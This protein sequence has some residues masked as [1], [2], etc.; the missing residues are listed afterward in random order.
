MDYSTKVLVWNGID[1]IALYPDLA[2]ACDFAAFDN[3]V[4]ISATHRFTVHRFKVH[5]CQGS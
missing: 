5:R 3:A 4:E 2:K 1:F